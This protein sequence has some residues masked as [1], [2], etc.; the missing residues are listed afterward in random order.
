MAADKAEIRLP[1][2]SPGLTTQE[3]SPQSISNENLYARIGYPR[4]GC[5]ARCQAC[6]KGPAI[7]RS[8]LPW[9]VG[10]ETVRVFRPLM[11]VGSLRIGEVTA[12]RWERI[13]PDR[14][15]IVERFY[16][17]EFDDTKTDAG[18]RSIPLDSHG[19]LRA[20]LDATWQRSQDRSIGNRMNSSSRTQTE[21]PETA[22]TC[23]VGI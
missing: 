11:A 7:P 12:L 3:P 22:A 15:E 14:I 9:N 23:C 20:V 8:F 18:H 17:R 4:P 16:E 21:A 5:R 2:A 10:G 6:F 1:S 19:I 13:N